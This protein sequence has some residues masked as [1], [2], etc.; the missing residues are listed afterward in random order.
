M[1]DF[2]DVDFDASEIEDDVGEE[3]FFDD[4]KILGFGR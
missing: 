1:A 2:P 3:A 4:S